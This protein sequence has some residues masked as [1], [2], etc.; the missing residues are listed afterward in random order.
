[1]EKLK[2]LSFA[3]E[4]LLKTVTIERDNHGSLGIQVTEGSDGKVYIQSVVP[5]GPASDTG[6]VFKGDQ[7]VAV[8]GQNLLNIKYA[9]AL[10]ILKQTD[11]KVEFILSQMTS[12][13][14]GTTIVQCFQTSGRQERAKQFYEKT[15]LDNSNYDLLKFDQKTENPNPFGGGSIMCQYPYNV[16]VRN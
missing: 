16:Q 3:D 14:S 11:N 9:D 10:Q 2:N 5:F 15:F 6:N 1:M 13:E 8:D 7:I 4:R 12:Q